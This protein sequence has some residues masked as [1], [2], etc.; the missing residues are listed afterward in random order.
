MILVIQP[1]DDSIP[2]LTPQ[3]R[4]GDQIDCKHAQET[5]KVKLM[6]QRKLQGRGGPGVA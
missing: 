4:L 5:L 6:G 3:V 1:S 2:M